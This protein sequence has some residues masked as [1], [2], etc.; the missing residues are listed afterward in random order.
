MPAV[1]NINGQAITLDLKHKASRV[2]A[3][4]SSTSRARSSSPPSQRLFMITHDVDEA[5]YLADRILL[6]TPGPG[7]RV[8]EAVCVDLARPRARAE[9]IHE[10]R[11]YAIRNRLVGFLTGHGQQPGSQSKTA[12]K[13]RGVRHDGAALAVTPEEAQ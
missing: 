2:C 10:P 12:T 4:T 5:I 8:A 1:E 9:I 13:A 11:Y 6:M 3:A 7:A